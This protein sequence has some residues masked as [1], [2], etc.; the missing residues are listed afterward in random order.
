MDF[1]PGNTNVIVISDDG[2]HTDTLLVI[3]EKVVEKP[4]SGIPI[5][6]PG[7][8]EAENFNKGTNGLSFFD[9]TESNQGGEF[10][11]DE[12]VDIEMC[13]DNSGGFNVG[14]I[15]ANE[16]L[17]Y[18]VNTEN[19]IY[20]ICLRTA[21]PSGG[22]SCKIYLDNDLVAT[23][24]I[25]ATGDWQNWS[26]MNMYNIELKEKIEKVLKLHINSGGF[27]LNY[28]EFVKSIPATSIDIVEESV[29]L[30]T[31]KK[32]ATFECLI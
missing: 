13:G 11:P 19:G 25:T 26:N 27:N 18:T 6:I 8:I 5:E 24:P 30:F 20:D 29:N 31:L 15:N 28:I 22:G 10:R 14:W 23:L 3:V 17:N 4:F 12:P 21:S 16:W 32:S 2:L 7:R 9:D 1:K